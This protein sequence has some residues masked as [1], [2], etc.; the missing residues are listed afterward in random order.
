MGIPVD[1]RGLPWGSYDS[2]DSARVAGRRPLVTA[3]RRK[4]LRPVWIGQWPAVL[5]RHGLPSNSYDYRSIINRLGQRSS[6]TLDFLGFGLPDKPAR[7]TT[8]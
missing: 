8:A 7:H 1:A 2:T 6:L 3:G 5:L 4:C